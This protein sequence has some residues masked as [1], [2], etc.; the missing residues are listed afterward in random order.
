LACHPAARAEL[1]RERLTIRAATRATAR[2]PRRIHSHASEEPDW[3]VG[4]AGDE[5]A[6][7]VGS[8]AVD[9]PGTTA[10][11]DVRLVVDRVGVGTGRDVGGR[12]VGLGSEVGASA[13]EVGDASAVRDTAAAGW[14]PGARLDAAPDAALRIALP[15][16]HPAAAQQKMTAANAGTSFSRLDTASSVPSRARSLVTRRG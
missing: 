9:A 4:A 6:G 14:L 3:L 8:G 15:W 1:R 13:G 16:P 5:A 2:I 11:D 10:G 12:V 7:D